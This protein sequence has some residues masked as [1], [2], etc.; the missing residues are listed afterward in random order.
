[1]GQVRELADS[2]PLKEHKRSALSGAG[3]LTSA[4]PDKQGQTSPPV[5]RGTAS[6]VGFWWLVAVLYILHDTV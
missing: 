4:T 1:M 2:K 3:T 6:V 5:A